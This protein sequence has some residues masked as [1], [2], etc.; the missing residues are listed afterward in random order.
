MS[1]SSQYCWTGI[2]GDDRRLVFKESD[3]TEVKEVQNKKG[4][5]E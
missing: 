1:Y 2:I 5:E 3:L 4:G